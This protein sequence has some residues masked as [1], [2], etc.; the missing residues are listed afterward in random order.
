MSGFSVSEP[1]RSN[2]GPPRVE[3]GTKL[4]MHSFGFE[5]I[6]YTNV[7]RIPGGRCPE[8]AW[9]PNSLALEAGDMLDELRRYLYRRG[10][11]CNRWK[12]ARGIRDIALCNEKDEDWFTAEI[13]DGHTGTITMSDPNG[14]AVLKSM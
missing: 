14:N 6:P 7:V 9:H 8:D 12:F 1:K 3:A 10:R 5:T 13:S 2:L 4:R 11:Q